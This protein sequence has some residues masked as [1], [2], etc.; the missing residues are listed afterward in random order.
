M[1]APKENFRTFKDLG[2]VQAQA[3]KWRD[4]IANVRV[5]RTTGKRPVDR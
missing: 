2:D 4:K 5:H 1:A 3:I